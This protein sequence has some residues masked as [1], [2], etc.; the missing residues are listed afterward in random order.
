MSAAPGAEPGRAQGRRRQGGAKRRAGRR[1]EPGGGGGARV[2]RPQR[3]WA[4][5]ECGGGRVAEMGE[6][7]GTV[8]EL[9]ELELGFGMNFYIIGLIGLTWAEINFGLEC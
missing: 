4:V 3:L 9:I 5:A 8:G 7:G 1:T 2:R 6:P